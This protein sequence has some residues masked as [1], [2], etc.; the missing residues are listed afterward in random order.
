MGLNFSIE[1]RETLLCKRSEPK[2]RSVNVCY[3]RGCYSLRDEV[4]KHFFNKAKK[5]T[6][7]D[8]SLEVKNPT[9]VYEI[10]LP[11]SSIDEIID[12]LSKELA[13]PLESPLFKHSTWESEYEVVFQ[14]CEEFTN[15][16]KFKMLLSTLNP[17]EDI[18]KKAN[19]FFAD[20]F[21]YEDYG[22]LLR[23]LED[24]R[25]G[26]ESAIFEIVIRNSY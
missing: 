7:I 9:D 19:I 2:E 11:L 12:F 8:D 26:R 4:M 17:Q 22:K 25:D 21:L 24:Y 15:L 16:L 10:I 6:P 1:L 18:E 3:W 13:K 5:V 20:Y 14:T 23:I